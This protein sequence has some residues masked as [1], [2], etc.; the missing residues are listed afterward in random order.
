MWPRRRGCHPGTRADL[1]PHYD[2]AEAMLNG[3]VYPFADTTA[4]TTALREVGEKL[5][6]EFILPKLAVTF[7]NDGDG[8]YATLKTGSERYLVK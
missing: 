8:F 2:R 4:K 5:G 7:A 1:D 3:Q 6:R